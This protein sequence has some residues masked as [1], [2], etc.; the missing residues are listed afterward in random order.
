M[1]QLAELLQ[2]LVT[3][4]WLFFVVHTHDVPFQVTLLAE[5]PLASV[6]LMRLLLGVH[7]SYV[8]V[9]ISSV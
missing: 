7:T 3:L 5:L 4:I 2:A 9:K 8:F 1:A 6:T